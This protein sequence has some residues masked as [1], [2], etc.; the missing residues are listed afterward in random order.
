MSVPRTGRTKT[1][2][3]VLAFELLRRY[4]KDLYEAVHG[5]DSWLM[6]DD[7]ALMQIVEALT[8]SEGLALLMSRHVAESLRRASKLANRS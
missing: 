2:Q 1:K 8:D 3:Q 5:K 7:D 4:I 6:S